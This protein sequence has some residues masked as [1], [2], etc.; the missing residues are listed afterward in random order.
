MIQTIGIIGA[1]FAGVTAAKVL[2]SFGYDVTVFEK[3]SDV[4]GVWS[5]SRCYPGL[6]TQNPKRPYELSDY[7]MPNDWPEWPYGEK[8]Q[9]YLES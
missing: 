2:K 7:P 5:A 3:E 9:E 1:G 6:T 4:G 8:V